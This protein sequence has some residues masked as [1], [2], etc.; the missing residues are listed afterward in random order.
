MKTRIALFALALA[1]AVTYLILKPIIAKA[2]DKFVAYGQL[3]TNNASATAPMRL[4]PSSANLWVSRITIY[5]RKAVRTDNVGDVWLGTSS[6]NDTQPIKIGA[7]GEVLI[8][9]QP[10]NKFNLYDFY[11]DVAN[12]DDGVVIVFH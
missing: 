5:G 7:G 12:A 10:G 6:G 9:C 8:E 11:L 4:A 3:L 2:D 1:A